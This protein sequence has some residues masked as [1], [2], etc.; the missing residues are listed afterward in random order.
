MPDLPETIAI[1]GPAASGK[2]TVGTAI[3]KKYGYLF[4]DTGLMYRAV[5]L[6]AIRAGVEPTAAAARALLRTLRLSVRATPDGTHVF[7]GEED[8]TGRLREP[9]V[10]RR[11]SEY[12]AIPEVRAAMVRQ[13]REVASRGKAV[14]AG[15]DIGT[16]VLP[17]A[18]LKLYFDASEEARATRR[19]EQATQHSEE[20]RRDIAN[21]DK[22]DSGRAV[23]PLRP[24]ED[25]IVIDTTDMSL[26]EVVRLALE[27]VACAAA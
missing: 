23:S 15:R 13:Q 6:A 9:G 27:K 17:N 20:A 5:T 7:L 4:L 10:E 24:A 16:V 26:D 14:L 25:A 1:D 12:A 18:P 11:V 21:R 22:L 2:T 3:A 8:V 19:G